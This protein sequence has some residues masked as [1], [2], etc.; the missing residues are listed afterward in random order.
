M[1]TTIR[2]GKPA[3]YYRKEFKKKGIEVLSYADELLDKMSGNK[4]E[5]IE[6]TTMTI[7][8]LGFTDYPTTTKL[9]NRVKKMGEL[10]PA[11]AG[12]A[13]RLAYEDQPKGNWLYTMMEPIAGSDGDPRVFSVRRRDDGEQWL[14]TDWVRPGR[15]WRLDGEIVFRLRKENSDP[16]SS[17]SS[18]P[19]ILEKAIEVCKEA[20]MVVYKPM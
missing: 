12:P 14:G 17:Q 13:L 5:A 11:E 4:E 16:L 1:K 2:I 18:E 15:G 6:V 9:F 7:R 10:L 8:E 20:G 19:L 3:D